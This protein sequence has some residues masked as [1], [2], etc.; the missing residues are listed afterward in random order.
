MPYIFNGDNWFKFNE[1]QMNSR[2][3]VDEQELKEE[4]KYMFDHQCSLQGINSDPI[5]L[6]EGEL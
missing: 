3:R 5:N 1:V 6:L 4:E 2:L